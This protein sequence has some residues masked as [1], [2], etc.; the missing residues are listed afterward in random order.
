MVN[1]PGTKTVSMELREGIYVGEGLPLVLLKLVRQIR[2]GEF[3]EME[4]LLPELWS[5]MHGEE[6][7]LQTRKITDIFSCIQCFNVLLSM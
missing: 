1:K 3:V 2:R 5:P 7:K 4:E 6:A